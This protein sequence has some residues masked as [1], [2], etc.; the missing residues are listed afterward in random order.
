VDAVAP[1]EDD[2]V[3]A[4][5]ELAER[6]AEGQGRDLTRSEL[7]RLAELDEQAELR[8]QEEIDVR[9]ALHDLDSSDGRARYIS[10]RLEVPQSAANPPQT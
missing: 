8:G 1:A 6:A 2:D 9:E 5:V 4:F 10:E 3:E 7:E